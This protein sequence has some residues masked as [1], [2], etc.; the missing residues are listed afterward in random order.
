MADVRRTGFHLHLYHAGG[1]A[2]DAEQ[3]IGSMRDIYGAHLK[4]K[5]VNSFDG[6][7]TLTLLADDAFISSFQKQYPEHHLQKDY[8]A[9]F[10]ALF[11]SIFPQFRKPAGVLVFQN[12]SV[13]LN[14][15]ESGILPSQE[16]LAL[17]Q[18]FAGT[19]MI[20]AEGYEET[21]D[22]IVAVGELTPYA[23]HQFADNKVQGWDKACRYLESI[24][25]SFTVDALFNETL[26]GVDPY[27]GQISVQV[28]KSP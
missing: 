8:T 25:T 27:L 21:D 13:T 24:F 6:K 9:Y 18:V 19:Y 23:V 10:E 22:S 15:E 26:E 5:D 7:T 11:M 2:P 28:I 16:F 4:L 14:R 3:M 1:G 17:F 20:L 12:L